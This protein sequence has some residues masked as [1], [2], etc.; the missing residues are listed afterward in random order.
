MRMLQAADP[1]EEING[2]ESTRASHVMAVERV[3]QTMREQLQDALLLEDMADIACLSPFYFNRIFHQVIGIPPGEFL[4]ALR[5]DTAKRL[6]LTTSLSVTDVCFEVGYNGLGSFTT[7]FT[8]LVGVPPR[9]LRY[10]VQNMNMDAKK[11]R[12][13]YSTNLWP[14]LSHTVSGYVYAPG[15]FEGN[16]YLGLFP[17]P[18]PQGRPIRCTM[19]TT[20]GPYSIDRVPN[21]SYYL[22]CAA[23]PHS[24]DPLSYLLPD[25]TTQVAI[26]GPLIM[27]NGILQGTADVFLRSLRKTDPPIVTL[28]SL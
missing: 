20:P 4:S 28:L 12:Q 8:Q 17:K 5:L 7:R 25:A 10:L 11:S 9:H 16:I 22:L 13:A 21:G 23:L 3:I 18:I 2:R 15:P 27:E 19:L 6:L 14:M 1:I 24:N 26:S